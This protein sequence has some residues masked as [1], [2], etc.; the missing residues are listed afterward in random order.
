[1]KEYLV[2]L[3]VQISDDTKKITDKIVEK[4]EYAAWNEIQDA[5]NDPFCGETVVECTL[6]EEVQR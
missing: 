6:W 5:F 1:M 4:I 2:H 3:N